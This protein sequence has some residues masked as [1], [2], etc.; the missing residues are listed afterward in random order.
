VAEDEMSHPNV[1]TLMSSEYLLTLNHLTH[2]TRLSYEQ[3][4][5]HDHGESFEYQRSDRR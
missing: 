4:K 1:L 3:R 5:N 2:T